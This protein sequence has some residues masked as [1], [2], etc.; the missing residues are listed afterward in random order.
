MAYTTH[1]IQLRTGTGISSYSVKYLGSTGS[2]YITA[3]VS[4]S[5]A[6]TD[7]YVR[8]G[9][10]LQVTSVNYSNTSSSSFQFKEYDSTWSELIKTFV[11][12]DAYIYSSGA[13]QVKLFATES[14]AASYKIKIVRGDGISIIG[15]GV[16]TK[17]LNKSL[18]S[19]SVTVD[20]GEGGYVYIGIAGYSNGYTYPVYA[21]NTNW[22]VVDAD[23][24]YD[25]RYINAPS[26]SGTREIEIYA[27]PK[28]YY[29]IHA[30]ANGGEFDDNE[31]IWNSGL[32]EEATLGAFA[33]YS[34]SKIPTPYRSGY[35]FAGWG[36]SAG[37]KYTQGTVSVDVTKAT[38]SNPGSAT[39]YAIWEE[40]AQTFQFR[41]SDTNAGVSAY[42]VYV[43]GKQKIS[44]TSTNWQ[45]I[46]VFNANKI[47]IHVAVTMV[48]DDASGKIVNPD[49]FE[50]PKITALA[51]DPKSNS[52]VDVTMELAT[53][54]T[55]NT[56]PTYKGYSFDAQYR[57]YHH[58]FLIG[59]IPKRYSVALNPNGGTWQD[60]QKTTEKTVYINANEKLKFNTHS[61]NLKRTSYKL[62][63]WNTSS[64][65][66]TGYSKPD[67]SIWITKNTTY[68]ATWKEQMEYF[69]WLGSD[70]KDKENVKKGCF[71]HEAILAEAWN[72]LQKKILDLSRKQSITPLPSSEQ[73]KSGYLISAARCN[74]VAENINKLPGH[75]DSIGSVKQ[76][77]E[78]T[79]NYFL[80]LKRAI[81]AA[82]AYFNGDSTV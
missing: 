77:D 52:D 32:Q 20:V 58:K 54:S 8:D 36:N 10:N 67:A 31:E 1:R 9:T 42:Y 47:E 78:M 75:G 27:T 61:N 71:V 68:Y 17:T 49:G 3:K 37:I 22:V 7:C 45:S 16:N 33:Y 74:A 25:D 12:G 18:T 81:N 15:Y 80:Q 73:V 63:G 2:D 6:S 72:T 30:N 46:S 65:A 39:V 14:T 23:G 43:D 5:V 11:E 55:S 51:D 28:R 34:L 57:P 53:A 79:A 4:S 26:S 44:S 29:Y 13:R 64:T 66:T 50:A 35:T 41:L 24:E 69:N 70:E 19:S 48:Y 40:K 56:A 76:G 82:I 62:L 59:A 38:A 21:N 60:T